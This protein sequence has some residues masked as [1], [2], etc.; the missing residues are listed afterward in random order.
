MKNLKKAFKTEIL[1]S[2]LQVDK[3]NRTIG[4][5]RY[6]YNLYL[7][8]AQERYKQTEKHLSGY[9]FSKWLNNVH[10]K[11]TD[12]WI[13]DVS[14]KAVKQAIMNGDKAFKN[15]FKGLAKF[16]R[17]KKKRNQ[18]VKAYFPKNNVT[19]L[20]VERHRIKVP[21][22]GWVRLKEFGYIPTDATVINCTLSQKAGRYFVS[23][24]CEVEEVREVY[25]PE[26]DGIGIDLGISTFAVCSHHVQ[27]DN[28]NKTQPVIKLEKSLKRQQ[29][30]LSR[31]YEQNKHRKR[32]EFCAK[33]RQKQLVVV[34]KLHARLANIRQAYIRSV[35]DLLVKTKPTYFTIEDLNV[36]VLM[37]NRHLS[38][39]VAQQCFYAF[40]GWLTAKCVEIGI[41]L[42]VVDMWYPSSK[43][44]ST[45]GTKKT[46]LSLSE[47][48][49]SCDSCDT[50]L[51]RDYNASLNLKY[52]K[53]YTVIT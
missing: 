35:V 49:F 13:K 1:L 47:R 52:A 17:F 41:E 4:T 22:V 11:E 7:H 2:N 21:T 26:H 44:C 9:D 20:T 46:K 15:F 19:D 30:K 16:P 48:I 3:V 29:R 27:F 14:S 28:I 53:E 34:Q 10:T 32:G 25:V 33:N 18:D 5:C 42:R 39:A 24:L 40:R 6:V 51:D 8:T 50:V 43:L 31:S 37:K 38:K 12:Q 23:V 36:T 45:C